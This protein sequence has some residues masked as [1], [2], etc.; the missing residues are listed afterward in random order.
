[1]IILKQNGEDWLSKNV[2][3]YVIRLKDANLPERVAILKKGLATEKEIKDN[4]SGTLA[5]IG[6]EIGESKALS[7]DEIDD[8][9]DDFEDNAFKYLLSIAGEVKETRERTSEE[10][11]IEEL[12]T[13]LLQFA[14]LKYNGS[15]LRI[16]NL[17]SNFNVNN[18]TIKPLM[19]K[20]KKPI[21][22]ISKA[23]FVKEL[24][25]KPNVTKE[26]TPKLY[27]R[28]KAIEKKISE[29]YKGVSA[30]ESL[31]LVVSDFN[32]LR[33][34]NTKR[35]QDYSTREKAYSHWE[36]VSDDINSIIELIS[37]S[38]ENLLKLLENV[39]K[40]KGYRGGKGDI[41]KF[42]DF[43]NNPEKLKNINY[44]QQFDNEQVEI[45]PMSER[46]MELLELF[47]VQN[48][49]IDTLIDMGYVAPA[50]V[51]TIGEGGEQVRIGEIDPQ[52]AEAVEET[53]EIEEKL[54]PKKY[55]LDILG[56]L[57]FERNL[58]GSSATFEGKVEDT[59]ELEETIE[60]L[61]QYV[62]SD[63][64]EFTRLVEEGEDVEIFVDD[65]IKAK[66]DDFLEDIEK[67]TKTSESIAAYFPIFIL[68]EKEI[69]QY[70]RNDKGFDRIIKVEESLDEFLL[71]FKNLIE[72]NVKSQ[73]PKNI[74]TGFLT[75][76]GSPPTKENEPQPAELFNISR[77][78]SG[79]TGSA[80]KFK[81]KKGTLL[82]P[83]NDKMAEINELMYRCFSKQ[84]VSQFLYGID[85]PFEKDAAIKAITFR[86][87]TNKESNKKDPL[88]VATK[89]F[90]E[91]P[92]AF[93]E[94]SQITKINSFLKYLGKEDSL[95]NYNKIEDA[96]KLFYKAISDIYDEPSL[97][98]R[99]KMET[100]SILGSVYQYSEAAKEQSVKFMGIDI[101]EAYKELFIE[102]IKDMTT[103]EV[104]G[105]LILQNKDAISNNEDKSFTNNLDELMNNLD[106]VTKSEI[107]KKL[108]KAH[109]SLRIL[110]SKPIHYALKNENSFEDVNN[111]ISKM[112]QSFGLDMGAGE[113]ISILTKIDSFQSIAEEHGITPEHVYVIKANF[114]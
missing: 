57:N 68:K 77:Y 52:I 38:G 102:E 12:R 73:T 49:L 37:G 8:F 51:E 92:E 7:D 94:E 10:E 6:E 48:N 97:N 64:D 43:C 11:K 63:F 60:Q 3:D 86:L 13:P 1:M 62:Q 83:I 24:I 31:E 39:D 33:V 5:D 106:R 99:I 70:Y 76:A 112:E 91:N 100:A 18:I 104:L 61:K 15:P 111:M 80:R 65:D 2:P 27:K 21:R 79:M 34:F 40:D 17:G 67:I 75:G 69:K 89:T 71:L 53:K 81:N 114:R 110:K 42:I 113:I 78:L 44:I 47:L 28:L 56:I 101:Q 105:N 45:S 22:T 20:G 108:L 87:K 96:A 36:S 55:D 30:K 54:Q 50:G 26:D 74:S 59:D 82:K 35:L 93:I 109:D 16:I 84:T 72:G 98:S 9:I 95:T 46:S 103:L 85:L 107:Q 32:L 19:T 58:K 88:Y 66:F 4:I 90:M 29:L 14:Q 23:A 41:E 25:T